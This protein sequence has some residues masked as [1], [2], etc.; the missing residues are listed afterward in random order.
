MNRTE[1]LNKLAGA[2]RA[3]RGVTDA[4]TGHWK[5]TP[6]QSAISLVGRWLAALGCAPV[7]SLDR[8]AK[9]RSYDEFYAWLGT[10]EEQQRTPGGQR[11]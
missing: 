8:I 5:Q 11:P 4:R 7:D 10:I 2:V 1:K 3:W 6:K 9:M